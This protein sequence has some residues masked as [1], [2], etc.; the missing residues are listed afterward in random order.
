MGSF[1]HIPL[2]ERCN[3]KSLS[4]SKDVV[5]DGYWGKK[6]RGELERNLYFFSCLEAER[7]E[8]KSL[9]KQY[10]SSEGNSVLLFC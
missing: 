8:V 7:S 10:F 3:G 1:L 9:K 6:R 5:I 2:K 4:P